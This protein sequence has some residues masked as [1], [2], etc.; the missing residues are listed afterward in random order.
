MSDPTAFKHAGLHIA[1]RR[2]FCAALGSAGLL[3]LGLGWGSSLAPAAAGAAD[4]DPAS[5]NAAS[6]WAEVQEVVGAASRPGLEWR[7]PTTGPKAMPGKSIAI[8]ADNLRNGGVLGTAVGIREATRQIGWPAKLFHSDGSVAGMENSLARAVASGA[9]GII[10]L[11]GDHRRMEPHLRRAA[12]D[13]KKI[14]GW[15]VAALPGPMAAS[16]ISLNI[17]TDPLEVAR[18]TALA[19]LLPSRGDIGAIIFTDNS[20]ELAR[21][22]AEQMAAVIR[23]GG[24]TLLE[25]VDM[26]LTAVPQQMRDMTR[27]L[28]AKHG[29][30]WTHALAINDIYFDFAVA[31]LTAQG[32]GLSGRELNMLSAGD[33]SASAILRIMASS[34]Q[35]STVAEPLNLQGWQSVD[36]LNRLFYGM[37]SSN[38]VAPA[39]LLTLA[40]IAYDGGPRMMFDPDNGYR[41]IY[42]G[43]WGTA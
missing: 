1:G 5:R 11:A 40:N 14:I 29:A 21:V 17:S 22:K 32:Q 16:P 39:H 36:E 9:D 7:G 6:K 25:V 37:P 23:A 12:D 43:I 20:I 34:F 31:Q 24:G 2:R 35:S 19:A 3:E 42:R 18:V 41:D 26:P 27:A 15:H 38:F 4:M 8:W 10:L 30:N 13:G 33:G 28:L